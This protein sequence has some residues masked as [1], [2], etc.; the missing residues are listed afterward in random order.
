MWTPYGGIAALPRRPAITIVRD[1]RD[2]LWFSYPGGSVAVLDGER[3]RTYG[4]ADGL[5]IG[6]VMANYPGRIGQWLG[7][8]LGTG[9]VRRR[10]ISERPV[11]GGAV[12]RR[13]HGCRRDHR[14][15]PLAQRPR[16]NSSYRER[17]SW[18]AVAWTPLI[19]C[20]ARRSA[21]STA[22]SAAVRWC[23]PCRPR[24]KPRMGSCGSPPAAAFTASIRRTR[25]H[26]RVPPPVLIRALTVA[27]HT[28][29]PIPGLTLPVYTTAVGFD[30]LGLSLTAAEKV[31]YRY[32]LDGV[33]YRLARAHRRAPGALHQPAPGTL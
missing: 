29:E 17:A 22:S 6:N 3:V 33:R 12:S 8:E 21:L 26:N 16:R 24:S 11:R 14:R 1:R 23:D 27:G 2:R 9:A 32:R 19:A 15:R 13:H 28:I 31:R 5:Q 4:A 20:T 30:Y 7:G 18:S 10:A 25:V